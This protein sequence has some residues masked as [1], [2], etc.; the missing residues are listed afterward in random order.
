MFT[1]GSL[2]DQLVVQFGTLCHHFLDVAIGRTVG[3]FGK[4][5]L[6]GVGGE[7]RGWPNTLRSSL[8][9]RRR[10]ARLVRRHNLAMHA[11]ERQLKTVSKSNL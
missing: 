3:A 11:I 7:R 8:P 5:S 10:T 6:D 9:E 4:K 1:H 2:L